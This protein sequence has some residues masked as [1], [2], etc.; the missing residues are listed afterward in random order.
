P[1]AVATPPPA[2]SATPASR[3]RRGRG[4]SRAPV[5]AATRAAGEAEAA[6]ATAGT[7]GT[8]TGTR[9]AAP[10]AAS[11]DPSRADADANADAAASGEDEAT[12]DSLTDAVFLFE[13]TTAPATAAP[14]RVPFPR[15]TERDEPDATCA[16]RQAL[17]E[18]HWA[19]AEK[20]LLSTVYRTTSK[21]ADQ[22][23][24]F[25]AQ[26]HEEL[27]RQLL[28]AAP[29]ADLRRWGAPIF[30]EIPT[31][32]LFTETEQQMAL[33]VLETVRER[34]DVPRPR[35]ATGLPKSETPLASHE[36]VGPGACRFA[37]LDHASCLSFKVALK[38]L[39]TQLM[40]PGEDRKLF[41]HDDFSD[42]SDD[43][44]DAEAGITAS[45]AAVAAR[46]RQKL[47]EST[48]RTKI[49]MKRFDLRT[50]A[51]WYRAT[52]QSCSLVITI[53]QIESF[54]TAVLAPLLQLMVSYT[55]ELPF[56]LVLGVATTWLAVQEAVPAPLMPHLRTVKFY[57]QSNEDLVEEIVERLFLE[58]S[59]G[60]ALG[61][62]VYTRTGCGPCRCTT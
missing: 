55:T 61:G 28:G 47:T 6:E 57:L 9:G 7:A 32:L 36:G 56:V 62:G 27:Q 45:A 51:A 50:L 40:F 41:Q 54:P 49:P 15:Y 37:I 5:A 60:L 44:A 48:A 21:D 16:R 46:K 12:Y 2:P 19:R 34:L 11:V 30:P 59:T 22:I 1:R 24:T 13:P 23:Y 10:G 17:Y 52:G 4:P 14:Q 35:E 33:N 18:T 43:E 29:S 3:P 25:L 39:V 42:D 8:A 58:P 26:A 53:P 20:M 31:A 38:L